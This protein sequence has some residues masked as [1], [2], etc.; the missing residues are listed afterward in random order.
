MERRTS[1]GGPTL[2]ASELDAVARWAAAAGVEDSVA[3]GRD[4]QPSF[5]RRVLRGFLLGLAIMLPLMALGWA[6]QG[7]ALWLVLVCG[8]LLLGVQVVRQRSASA[9]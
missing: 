4:P 3:R 1:R 7:G 2:S 8:L 5:G 6:A 9:G